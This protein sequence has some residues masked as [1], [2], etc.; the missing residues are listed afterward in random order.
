MTDATYIDA[1]PK[2]SPSRRRRAGPVVSDT[3]QTDAGTALSSGDQ[4][5][6]ADHALAV[7]SA[8]DLTRQGSRTTRVGGEI[9]SADQNVNV[10]H[11]QMESAGGEGLSSTEGH[12]CPALAD[13]I[14]EVVDLYRVRRSLVHAEGDMSRRIQSKARSAAA[15]RMRLHGIAIPAGKQATAT[16]EDE[17]VVLRLYPSFYAAC[18]LI[19]AQRKEVEKP[20]C[21]AARKL[22]IYEWAKGVRGLGDLSLAA[23]VGEA[24]DIGKYRSVAALWKRMGLAVID[25]GRQ[26]LIAGDAALIHGY[27]PM[28]RAAMHVIG[29]NLI[30]S[31]NPE[32]RALYDERKAYELARE[33]S[34]A[35]AHNRSLRY[36]EK[37]LLREMWK[38]WRRT[39]VSQPSGIHLSGADLSEAA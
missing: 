38:A 4:L 18:D 7:A 17:A 24:G 2:G 1:P 34:K 23:I 36:I 19:A 29:T 25:G 30:R 13:L 21:K 28:R 8:P 3:L 12:K 22:P 20:L 14:A 5:G 32:Y 27:N 37:R 26:R 15:Y 16:V 33:V 11:Q 9:S 31:A 39:M 35:Q 6:S 10:T